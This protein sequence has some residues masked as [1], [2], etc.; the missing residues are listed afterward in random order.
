MI[1]NEYIKELKELGGKEAKEKLAEYAET[2]GITVKK[3]K[4]FDNMVLDLS[5]KLLELS[6]EP[7]PDDNEGFTISD[8]ITASDQKNGKNIQ[9]A[10]DI[11]LNLT[12]SKMLS[13]EEIVDDI[14]EVVVESVVTANIESNVTEKL[15]VENSEP[16]VEVKSKKFK[17][18]ENFS[19]KITLL[20]RSPGYCTLPWWIYEWITKNSDWKENTGK[21]PHHYGMDT[22]YSLIYYINRDGSVMIRET[23]NSKFHV[24][25]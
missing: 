23:R 9:F 6:N 7:M 16:E 14:K 18:P 20:G 19:P 8:L 4:S 5:D 1:D 3:T 17:L 21:F 22:L 2:F 13:I 15:K 10:G 11:D 24:L 12:A 25:E